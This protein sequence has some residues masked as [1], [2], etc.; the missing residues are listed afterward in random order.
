MQ[1]HK[2]KFQRRSRYFGEKFDECYFH[3]HVV[4]RCNRFPGNALYDNYAAG[5]VKYQLTQGYIV[6]P[7]VDL[8]NGNLSGVDVSG[9]NVTGA[10][11]YDAST[12]KV[13]LHSDTV[14][15]SADYTFIGDCHYMLART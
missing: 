3:K 13:I 6:G 1:F 7:S 4:G 2:R 8:T 12:G 14:L 5:N 9:I 10:T 11:F 15:P